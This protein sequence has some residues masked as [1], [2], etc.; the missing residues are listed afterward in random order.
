MRLLPP[1]AFMS[2]TETSLLLC[3]IVGTTVVETQGAVSL[4][5]AL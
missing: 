3:T 2:C 4:R 5:G 1:L